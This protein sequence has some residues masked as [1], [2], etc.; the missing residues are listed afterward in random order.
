MQSV[1]FSLLLINYVAV[2]SSKQ[3]ESIIPLAMF[4]FFWVFFEWVGGGNIRQAQIDM[5][6]SI[7]HQCYTQE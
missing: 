3:T 2:L 1:H 6:W 4:W 7:T 5:A